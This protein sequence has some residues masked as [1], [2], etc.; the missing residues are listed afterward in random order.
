LLSRVTRAWFGIRPRKISA[1]PP[2][3]PVACGNTPQPLRRNGYDW[4][5]PD[6]YQVSGLRLLWR[7]RR[8]FA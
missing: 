2:R 7:T 3:P 1:E 6:F 5:V 8:V 4:S